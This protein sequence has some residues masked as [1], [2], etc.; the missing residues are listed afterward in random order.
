M[1]II[2]EWSPALGTILG[3]FLAAISGFAVMYADRWLERRRIS[4]D[5][6]RRLYRQ[7]IRL[8]NSTDEFMRLTD[9]QT[10]LA[11][12]LSVADALETEIGRS[13]SGANNKILDKCE[14]VILKIRQLNHRDKNIHMKR[15]HSRLVDLAAELQYL[16][17]QE[18][19]ESHPSDLP[20]NV[21]QEV[22]ERLKKGSEEL[23]GKNRVAE[24][25]EQ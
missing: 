2:I 11:H 16:V 7:S 1:P 12:Y 8:P 9:K 18:I 13:P 3:G 4:K 17:E 24:K 14:N 23:E 20:E 15:H 5:W 25:E 10:R 21:K 22:K 19:D 6:Y